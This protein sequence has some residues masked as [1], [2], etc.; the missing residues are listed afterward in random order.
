M[1]KKFNTSG[2]APAFAC[3]TLIC[4]QGI[5]NKITLSDTGHMK[6]SPDMIMIML[7]VHHHSHSFRELKILVD[8]LWALNRFEHDIDWGSLAD[9]LEKIGLAKTALISLN[10]IR[11]LW[12]EIDDNIPAVRALEK[13]LKLSGKK[14]PKL[15]TKYFRID[16]ERN[17]PYSLY[18]DK[19]VARFALDGWARIGMSFLKTLMPAP[20]AIK[21]LY[22]DYRNLTLPLN[23][24]RFISWRIKEW[25]T[26]RKEHSAERE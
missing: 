3:L 18:K 16:V 5:W 13:N 25:T 2:N 14:I 6:L 22:R 20:V 10:Q 23:Y 1:M 24:L 17:A 11:S 4:H 19:F 7:L 9:R 12:D 8:I 15:L 21:E 26:P